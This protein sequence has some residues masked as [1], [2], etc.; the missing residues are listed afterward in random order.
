MVRFRQMEVNKEL[1]R[2]WIKTKRLAMSHEEVTELSHLIQQKLLKEINWH[3]LKS[4]NCY[5]AI[6]SLNEVKTDEITDYIR[7]NHADVQLSVQAQKKG[8]PDK[9]KYDLIIVPTLA[10]DSDGYRLGW[11]GGHYDRFL[12]EQPQALK[13]GLCFRNGFT[14]RLLP[15]ERHDISLDKVITEV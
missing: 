15:H 14:K 8:G 7:Q 10:F 3:N 1:L 11:G 6:E 12:S 2:A 13:V 9:T 5:E 4:I